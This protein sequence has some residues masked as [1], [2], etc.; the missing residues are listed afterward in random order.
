MWIYLI[1]TLFSCIFFKSADI[2]YR[3]N[4]KNYLYIIFLLLIIVISSSIAGFRSDQVGTD[5]RV[6]AE[7]LQQLANYTTNFRDFLNN[8]LFAVGIEKGYLSLIFL[9]SRFTSKLF[10]SQLLVELI[11][12]SCLIIGIWKFR[13]IQHIYIYSVIG[14]LIFYCFF[15]NTSFNMIRQ[16]IAMFILFYSFNFLVKREKVKWLICFI[17]AFLFHTSAV[18]GLLIAIIYLLTCDQNKR[19]N[20]EFNNGNFGANLSFLR[21]GIIFLVTSIV[22]FFPSLLVGLMHIAKLDLYVNRYLSGATLQLSISNLMIRLLLLSTLFIEWNSM[23]KQNN[24]LKYFYILISLIDIL[25][26][27]LSGYTKRIGWY[28]SMFYIYSIP[29]ALENDDNKTRQITLVTVLSMALLVYWYFYSV[30]I[31]YGETV[32]YVFGNFN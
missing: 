21:A 10:V 3:K 32:P 2:I 16:S 19:I 9:V 26:F 5:V 23:S 14:I 29:D 30:I 8:N 7:P 4:H 24:K 20:F 28:T 22:I 6:Y 1:N 18:M 11:I 15:Y 25:L 13:K 17:I 27:Q 12:M 31:N